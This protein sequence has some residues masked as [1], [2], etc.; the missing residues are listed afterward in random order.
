MLKPPICN[1]KP[2][3]NVARIPHRAPI[4]P[5]TKFVA[6][7]INS[8]NENITAIS[9]AVNDFPYA[10]KSTII[11]T[12]PSVIVKRMYETETMANGK[13][14]WFVIFFVDNDASASSVGAAVVTLA[15]SLS[16]SVSVSVSVSPFR[17][18]RVGIDIDVKSGG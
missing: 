2:V 9:I 16:L 17:F 5:A 6:T 4:I 3:N 14:A 8:Y 13:S 15:I 10:C 18:S 7:P 12:A 11:R 1:D